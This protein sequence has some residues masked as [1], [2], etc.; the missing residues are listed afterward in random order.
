MVKAVLVASA[1]Q[2]PSSW[3]KWIRK[4]YETDTLTCSDCEEPMWIIT[5]ITDRREI[6]KILEYI[7]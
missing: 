7:G 3:T 4:I 2:Q 1:R 5:F 6:S